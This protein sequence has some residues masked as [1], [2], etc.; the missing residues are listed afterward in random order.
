MPRFEGTLPY[1]L[2]CRSMK[3]VT[4]ML[5]I[6]VP[7]LRYH[8]A[9]G[10][11]GLWASAPG[12]LRVAECWAAVT[13]SSQ[14][15]PWLL[16]S[17][18]SIR[19]L[20]KLPGNQQQYLP[21][22]KAD[23]KWFELIY[24]ILLIRELGALL[25]KLFL[26]RCVIRSSV[27]GSRDGPRRPRPQPPSTCHMVSWQRGCARCWLCQRFV[28]SQGILTCFVPW[29]PLAGWQTTSWNNVFKCIKWN[30]YDFKGNQAYWNRLIKIFLNH[31]IG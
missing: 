20:L 7:G 15:A 27:V 26:I 28:P 17:S 16:K 14:P 12:S 25:E 21:S 23:W 13:R 4:C 31:L 2:T 24:P 5:G 9:L 10:W 19:S 18:T 1:S 3:G 30:A 29:T 6:D 8:P 22:A 11:A